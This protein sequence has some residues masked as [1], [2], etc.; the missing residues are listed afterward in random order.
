MSDQ[1]FIM[2]RFVNSGA[3]TPVT[4]TTDDGECTDNVHLFDTEEAAEAWAASSA[5]VQSGQ[6]AYAV[7]EVP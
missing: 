5:A 2:I 7:Y 6:I 3:C 1:Y 4:T